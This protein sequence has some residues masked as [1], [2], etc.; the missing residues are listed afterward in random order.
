MGRPQVS[1]GYSPGFSG[2]ARD[3]SRSWSNAWRQPGVDP[4]VV[5]R[6]TAPEAPLGPGQIRTPEGIIN[7]NS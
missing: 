5:A 3:L 2:W 4:D 1:T 6:L 7:I